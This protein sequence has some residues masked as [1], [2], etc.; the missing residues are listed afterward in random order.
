MSSPFRRL[1]AG[2]G[3]LLLDGGMGTALMANGLEPGTSPEAWNLTHPEVIRRIHRDYIEAG[4]RVILTNS[5]GG[6]RNRLALSGLGDQ[7]TVLNE[8]A[9]EL[10]RTEADRAFHT[11]A[12]AGSIGPT[13]EL[14]EPLGTLTVATAMEAFAEQAEALVEGGVDLIWIET[15]SDLDEAIAAV[16]GVRSVCDLDITVTM[17]FG[18]HGHTMMGVSPARA[19]ETLC[20]LDLAAI[21]ANCGVGSADVEEAVAAMRAIDSDVVLIAKSNAG[22]PCVSDGEILYPEGP[23]MMAESAHRLRALGVKLIGACC[24]STPRHLRAMA[25]ALGRVPSRS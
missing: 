3:P 11:V 23:N 22:L 18:S 16:D 13:G 25:A 5:F 14:L 1:L 24:G 6:T 21:G 10:A 2:G 4:S 7:V 12:V 19:L 9:A 20:R 17:S 15:M 8:S